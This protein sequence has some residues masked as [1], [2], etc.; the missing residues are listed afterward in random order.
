ME[1]RHSD[2]AANHT[3]LQSGCGR[4]CVFA[5]QAWSNFPLFHGFGVQLVSILGVFHPAP[6]VRTDNKALYNAST[7]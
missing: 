1:A 7:C 2:T 3:D 6:L 4:T 5:V